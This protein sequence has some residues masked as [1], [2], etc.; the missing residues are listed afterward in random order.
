[1]KKWMSVVVLFMLWV[2][3]GTVCA[4]SGVTITEMVSQGWTTEVDFA[5]AEMF[6]QETGIRVDIQVVPAAQHH[7]LLKAKLNAGEAPDV[8]WI[9]TNP[10]AIKVELDPEKNC[11]DLSNEKWVEVMNP[12]R[13]PSV[14]YDDKVYGL[15]L[16]H[17]SPEYVFFYNKTL[18]E[19][20]GIDV[21]TTYDALKEACEKI[22]SENITPIY[23]YTSQ[24]WHQVL[25][26]A[27]IGGRYEELYP[28]IYD[29]LNN[30]EVKF[31][32]VPAMLQA[33]EQMK[34]MADKGYYGEDFL[35]NTGT[36][37][38]IV[39]SLATGQAAMTLANP[40]LIKEIEAAYPDCEYEW[41]LFLIPIIDNQTYPFNPNG[42]ARFI[43]KNSK[44]I[45]A[46]KKYFE[47]LTRKE[48]LQ[49]RIDHHP[50][51]TNLDV[52][53]DIEQHWLPMEIEL[54][55][56]IPEDKFKLVLQSGVKYFNEQWMEV[57]KDIEAMY[58]GALEPEEI[59]KNVDDRRAKIAKAI[60]DPAWQ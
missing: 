41:G 58:I 21:P 17:N 46:A 12:L 50:E 1:M 47:F 40:G 6:T 35:A 56:K 2:A 59:L 30:N 55:E 44:N 14:S 31:V 15:M 36:T 32:D 8:F 37:A 20:L 43:Y 3:T 60:G 10:F 34:E 54:I 48:N 19:E 49:Y 39:N 18:F 16:W 13:I 38:E 57:G 27:Q 26:F 9:Q 45:E 5:L 23:E 22:L 42:P 28:G 7:D 52:T 11:V 51:W 29:R 33:L 24:G 53:V 4:Q 25:P